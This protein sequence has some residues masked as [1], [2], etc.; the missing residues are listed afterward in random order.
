MKTRIFKGMAISSVIVWLLCTVVI[1]G[2]FYVRSSEAGFD[3]M[4]NEAAVIGHGIERY[5]E[6]YVS[7]IGVEDSF[8]ITWIDSDGTV[9]YDSQADP[10]VMENHAERPEVKDAL[11]KGEGK[12]ER[13]SG[14]LSVVSRYYALALEDGTVVRIAEDDESVISVTMEVLKVGVYVLI[15][16]VIVSL[17][18]AGRISGSIVKPLSEIDLENPDVTGVYPEIQPLV[19]RISA[20][21]ELLHRQIDE[22]QIDVDQKTREAEFRKEFTA[23]VSHELKTPLTSISG[24]AEIMKN[25]LVKEDDI[26]RFSGRIYDEAQR[27]ITLVGDIIKLSQLD[28]KEVA[29]IKERLDLLEICSEQAKVLE[30]AAE[31]NEVT[32][33]VEGKPAYID[34]VSQ[35]VSEMVYNLCDNAVKYNVKGGKVTVGTF[36][37]ADGRPGLKVSDTGIGIPEEDKDRV[38]ERFFRVNKSHSKEIGGTGLGLSIVKHA[39]AFHEAEV[40]LKSRQGEGTEVTV[41]FPKA[42]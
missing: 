36:T 25:G 13:M 11:T 35:I 19:G 39:A 26:P 32:I 14:T 42:R 6:D 23:N 2:Y 37:A 4:R 17:I 5:G 28:E 20:Q 38:F 10:D 27:L 33:T 22:L 30:H 41:I 1:V 31:K 7:D 9:L 12:S 40:S 8:R 15:I 29:A 21:N 34:G 24:F 3:S 16:A 18:M